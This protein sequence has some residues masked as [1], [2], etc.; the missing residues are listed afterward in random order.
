MD[1][2]GNR[3]AHRIDGAPVRFAAEFY[4]SHIWMKCAKAYANS[5]GGLCERC[6]ARGLIVPGEEVHHKVKL[7]PEN[8]HDPSVALNWENLELLC[9]DCHIAE[10]RRKRWRVDEDGHVLI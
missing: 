6:A 4:K 2:H 7:T 3:E 10:H 5:R 8:I 1:S 9:K